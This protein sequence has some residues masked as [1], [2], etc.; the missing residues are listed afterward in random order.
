[1]WRIAQADV[2]C[3]ND[4][5]LLRNGPQTF[6][7]MEELIASAKDSVDL[8][9]YIFRDDDMG[10]RFRAALIDAAKRGVRVRLLVDWF[11]RTG[12]SRRFFSPIQ[13]AGGEVRLFQPPGWRRYMGVLPRDHRKLVVA[14]ETVGITG[15]IGIGDQ[16][17]RGILVRRSSPW[18]DTAVRIQGPA[19]GDMSESFERMWERAGGE[20]QLRFREVRQSRASHLDPDLDPPSLVGIIEGEPGRFR[21][22]RAR[23]MSALNADTTIWI[24]SAYFAPSWGLVEALGGAATDGVDVR[25]LIP[26]RYDHPWLRTILTPYYRRLLKYGVRVWEWRGEMMHAKTSVVDG[27]WVRVG[28]TDFNVLGVAINYELDAIIEDEALGHLA[29]DM[30]LDDLERSREIYYKRIFS[31]YLPPRT[32]DATTRREPPRTPPRVGRLPQ[33]DEDPPERLSRI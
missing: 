13:Q 15:G 2:S 27:R 8:E 29:Q 23:Q 22:S 18:R 11:G 32:P 33:D 25:V 16:W 1:L 7:A 24:A 3:G 4:C 12:T 26:S 20:R 19:A 10:R 6:D 28:S 17:K 21:V 30:F 31:R 14:D 9:Q 5:L